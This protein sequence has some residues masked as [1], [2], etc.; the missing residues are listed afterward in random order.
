MKKLWSF[1]MVT[2]L[3]LVGLLLSLSGSVVVAQDNES[4]KVANG[5]T[6]DQSA[7][8]FKIPRGSIIRHLENGITEVYK[9]DSSLIMSTRDSEAAM[10]ATPSGLV[11][12]T[13]VYGL[14]SGSEIDNKGD[15]TD[16]YENDTLILRVVDSGA[17]AIPSYNGWIE[18]AYNWAAGNL[19]NFSANWVVPSNPPSPGANVV[20]FLFPA[21]EPQSG[22]AI[23]QPV[24]GWNQV[25][26]AGW[27]GS[28]WYGTGNSYYYSTPISTNSGNSIS[29]V[30]A[31]NAKLGWQ[32]TFTNSTNSQSTSLKTKITNN[33]NLAVFTALEG[34]NIASISDVPGDTTFSGMSFKYKNN[35]VN[36]T[37]NP[38]IAATGIDLGLGIDITSS[39]QVTLNTAN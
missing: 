7:P 31:F 36:M 14:P 6:L 10:V 29:G 32:I 28:S 23:I 5:F 34:Y 21:I 15:T 27:T 12:A 17:L 33:K 24:L 26:R 35:Y 38:F 13:H 11:R 2:F 30:M 16:V 1:W 3:S 8:G 25:G 9:F 18:S 22:R 19:D 20:D 4:T 37:W 39:S